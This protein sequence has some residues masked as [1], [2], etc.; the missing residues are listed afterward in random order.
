MSTRK[1]NKEKGNEMAA[2]F[3]RANQGLDDIANEVAAIA[4]QLA[5]GGLLGQTG[6]ALTDVLGNT[7]VQKINLLSDKMKEMR[8]DVHQAK[9]EYEEA[10]RRAQARFTY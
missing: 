9:F 10:E 7:L 8:S 4:N 2:T 3:S 1:F 5:A 6:D